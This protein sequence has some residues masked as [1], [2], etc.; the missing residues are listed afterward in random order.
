MMEKLGGYMGKGYSNGMKNEIPNIRRLSAEMVNIPRA[1][2]ELAMAGFNG[3]FD[4][5]LNYSRNNSYVI[6]VPVQVDGRTIAH[7]SAPYTEEE[8]AKRESRKNR[9]KGNK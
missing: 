6:E 3:S 7:V 5:S 4:E 1:G 8:L 2:H 9:R